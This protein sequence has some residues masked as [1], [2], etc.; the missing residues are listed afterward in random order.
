MLVNSSIDSFGGSTG[1]DT[2]QR[3]RE[4]RELAALADEK[5]RQET[6]LRERRIALRK[7]PV[8]ELV[9]EDPID[10]FPVSR[11]ND[12]TNDTNWE[13]DKAGLFAGKSAKE[14]IG[15]NLQSMPL[16]QKISM[17]ASADPNT[18][19]EMLEALTRASL[20]SRFDPVTEND[21]QHT[22]QNATTERD[23]TDHRKM[24]TSP[25]PSSLPMNSGSTSAPNVAVANPVDANGHGRNHVSSEHPQH[26]E[27][28]DMVGRYLEATATNMNLLQYHHA[29]ALAG[30]VTLNRSNNPS[31]LDNYMSFDASTISQIRSQA[32]IAGTGPGS[33]STDGRSSAS[34]SD[35]DSESDDISFD[36]SASDRSDGSD[37]GSSNEPFTAARAM[38]L[39]RIQQQQRLQSR[40]QGDGLRPST[41][42][43]YQSGDSIDSTKAEDSCGSDSSSSEEFYKTKSL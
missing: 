42:S 3:R 5:G 14:I 15:R 1:G 19:R 37:S 13:I 26:N 2:S 18:S 24:T 6:K 4:E 17:S 29:V 43:D 20:R 11:S 27:E 8:D 41:D 7:A 35:I 10:E 39:N 34:N 23:I 32:N 38:L 22:L 25:P 16:A 21:S 31:S 28:H 40:H 9:T 12:T 36:D 30:G 33:E